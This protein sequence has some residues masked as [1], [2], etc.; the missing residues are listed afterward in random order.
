M[1]IIYFLILVLLPIVIFKLIPSLFY[2]FKDKNINMAVYTTYILT[3]C[4]AIILI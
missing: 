1:K 3:G 4:I 2:K